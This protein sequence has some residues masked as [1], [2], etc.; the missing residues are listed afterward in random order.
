[1]ADRPDVLPY[2]ATVS[3]DDRVLADSRAAVRVD[4]A[5]AAPELWFPRADVVGDLPGDGWHDGTGDLTGYVAFDHDVVDVE[6]ID[7]RD[8]DDERDVTTKRFPT[9][10]DAADLIGLLDVQPIGERTYRSPG[11]ADW[12]RPVVEGSQ[13]LGEAIV[14]AGR[15]VPGRRVVSSWMCFTRPADA[16]ADH[17]VVL[18]EVASG[19][20]F[21]T[22]GV[23][24]TQAARTCAAGMVLLDT[25]APDVVRHAEPAPDVPG[26]Y[27]SEPVDMSV[28]GRD[29]RI[30][31][32]A[33]SGDPDAPVGP[34]CSTPGCA[35]VTCPT[36]RRSTP[37]SSPSSRATCRSPPHCDRTPASGRI[38]RTSPCRPRST[39]S[40]SRSTPTCASTSGCCTTTARRSP[41]TA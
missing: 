39:P 30:V 31:D 12:R 20:T 14:A 24:A 35:S 36:T 40:P 18:D 5:D 16:R 9:W 8:G 11:H 23:R 4:R 27:D 37:G 26:P 41:V 29:L 21:S 33:Y 25:T 19:R 22:F 17:E 1:V 6:V 28:T 34:P 7:G 3:L 10:G 38:R 2:R 13:L 15:Q 32:G